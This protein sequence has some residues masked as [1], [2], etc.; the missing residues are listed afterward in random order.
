MHTHYTHVCTFTWLQGL[1]DLFYSILLHDSFGLKSWR[2]YA[3]M[4][5]NRAIQPWSSN[6]HIPRKIRI[7]LKIQ[8]LV[9]CYFLSTSMSQEATWTF[10]WLTLCHGV[11]ESSWKEPDSQVRHGSC[12]QINRKNWIRS[13]LGDLSFGMISHSDPLGIKSWRSMP[14]SPPKKYSLKVCK[15]ALSRDKLVVNHQ[16][17]MIY[18]SRLM[19]W[20]YQKSPSTN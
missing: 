20:W 8:F 4:C 14:T 13:C 11:R 19:E 5:F 12:Q 17:G 9:L 1:I 3:C 15:P 10:Q 6:M 18:A 2:A 7:H 16:L